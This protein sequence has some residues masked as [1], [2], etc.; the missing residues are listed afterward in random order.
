L[1][2]ESFS[3]SIAPAFEARDV[4]R[5]G[6]QPVGDSVVL[7]LRNEALETHYINQLTLLE[8][9]HAED[10]VVYPDPSGRALVVDSF[11]SPAY[12]VDSSSRIVTDVLARPDGTAWRAPDERLRRVADDDFEDHIDLEFDLPQ[13]TRDED[14]T[15]RALPSFRSA[16]A[17]AVL[18]QIASAH[19]DT[20]VGI[21]PSKDMTVPVLTVPVFTYLLVA[22]LPLLI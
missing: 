2:A 10:E 18:E 17:A 7:E 4:D 3:Y 21:T 13:A 16:V 20:V 22:Q 5:L 12:A 9:S 15:Y 11:V 19:P 14:F 8:I 6:V 1:E